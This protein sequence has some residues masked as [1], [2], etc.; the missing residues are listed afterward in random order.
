MLS[1]TYTRPCLK[2][3]YLKGRGI[4]CFNVGREIGQSCDG[5]RRRG[6]VKGRRDVS[7]EDKKGIPHCQ[8]PRHCP[9]RG[10]YILYFVEAVSLCIT[11]T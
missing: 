9:K 6:E 8:F 2:V 7:D 1:E 5:Q 11:I 3:C 10:I 4:I